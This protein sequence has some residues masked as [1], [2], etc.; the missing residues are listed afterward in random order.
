[1]YIMLYII[2]KNI[3][4]MKNKLK[5]FRFHNNNQTQEDLAKVL[6]ISRQTVIAIE[7]GKFNPSVKLGLKIAHYFNCN[8]EDIFHL[9]K[10]EEL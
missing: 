8:V 4:K 6:G 1:M 7:K 5:E 3:K 10:E 2:S 9:E